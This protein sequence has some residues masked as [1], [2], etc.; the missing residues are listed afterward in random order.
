MSENKKMGQGNFANMPQE[1]IMKPYPKQR[2]GDKRIDDTIQ[3][4]DS[5]AAD[6][7]RKMKK[8]MSNGMY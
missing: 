4:L 6:S 5:D 7:E 1:P 2:T 8:N 3:R